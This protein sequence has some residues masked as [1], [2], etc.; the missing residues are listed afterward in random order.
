MYKSGHSF[1]AVAY[2]SQR[3]KWMK[4][5]LD[6]WISNNVNFWLEALLKFNRG[7]QITDEWSFTLHSKI[8]IIEMDG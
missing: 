5:L 2:F 6:N 1:L 7:V 4:Q 3:E 8:E